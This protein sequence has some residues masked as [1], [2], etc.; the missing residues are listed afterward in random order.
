[1]D[2]R[3]KLM[4]CC[5]SISDGDHQPPPKQNQGIPFITIS[6]FD[7]TNNISFN[8]CMYVSEK[9]YENLPDIKKVRKGDIL[10]S[11]VGSFGIPILI[12]DDKKFVFQRHIAILRP[13]KEVVL[14]E[15]LYYLLLNPDFY[16]LADKYAIGAAQRTISLA[17]LRNMEVAIHTMD[18]QIKIVEQLTAIDKK[19]IINHKINDNLAKMIK[20]TYNHMFV[21]SQLSSSWANKKL[22]DII[23]RINTGL[24]P[25]D[26]FCLGNGSIKYITVKNL[27]TDGTL[28]FSNC[29]TINP[30][31]RQII[32]SR[33]DISV[34]D[35]LFA[36]IAPLGRCF[37]IQTH[38]T[39]W[40]INE[41]VF[42]IRVSTQLVSSEYLYS[43]FMSDQF[44]AKAQ[45]SSTGSIF[46]G[47]RIGTL[48]DMD[49]VI[50]PSELINEF[51]NTTKP[52]FKAKQ[53]C[54]DE[55]QY[56][57]K[58]RDWLLP[59]LMNGQATIDD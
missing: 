27:T 29:D 20:D 16:G 55:S 28:D 59:M 56:L 8:N 24:N 37:L 49:I 15:Y 47:I 2:K 44:I 10:Y 18:E 36:S 54:I 17:S 21:C 35:I 57:R 5:I 6:N 4:E 22:S 9:Y 39:D 30:A 14:P 43:Y 53:R 13:N 34:G 26:N 12:T 33:S 11:V 41:S 1:M 46:K 19:I 40:D 48:L 52:L 32:H 31:A 7:S 58:L 25:R 50:P 45:S 51:T 3:L 42:S 38:P 23:V